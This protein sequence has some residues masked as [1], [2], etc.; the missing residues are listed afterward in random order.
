[1]IEDALCSDLLNPDFVGGSEE[2]LGMHVMSQ[3][4]QLADL[5]D[6]LLNRQPAAV[7]SDS[8]LPPDHFLSEDHIEEWYVSVSI[9]TQ[10]SLLPISNSASRDWRFKS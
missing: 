6:L 2:E 9:G 7:P 4:A 8:Y 10:N 1:M 5:R 3:L